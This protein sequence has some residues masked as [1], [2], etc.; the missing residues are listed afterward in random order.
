MTRWHLEEAQS[1]DGTLW[2]ILEEKAG[3][4]HCIAQCL[5]EARAQQVLSALKWV[6]AMGGT[7]MSLAMEGVTFDP[8]T[9]LPRPKQTRKPR[10]RRET[11][12]IVFEPEHEKPKR[13]RK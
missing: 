12:E 2:N 10:A 1:E 7:H 3:V 5:D 13:R 6:D 4:L 11:L 9:G 8:R